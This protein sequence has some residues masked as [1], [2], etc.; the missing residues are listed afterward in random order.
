MNTHLDNY[1]CKKYP[2]IFAERKKPMS[3]TCMCWG[4]SHDDG[5]FFLLDGLCGAI[6][7]HIDNPPYVYKKTL[8]VY[9]ARVQ[10]W[11]ARKCH[12]HFRMLIQDVGFF[13]PKQIPQV[14][15][16][17]VKEK[18]ASLRFY[19]EGGDEQISGMV[20]LAEILSCQICE[21]CGMMNETVTQNSKGWLKTTCACCTPHEQKLDH[22][23][24]RDRKLLKL[25]DKVH[26]EQPKTEKEKMKD[27]FKEIANIKKY[28]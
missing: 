14:V 5:W 10:N 4:F 7:R 9:A 17:Q 3:Q 25:W 24:N 6:Q 19:Y 28:K 23:K 21:K 22:I 8:K 13:Q 12:F 26:S 11:I 27:T 16:K 18:F 15:A 2:K 20:R 1:L